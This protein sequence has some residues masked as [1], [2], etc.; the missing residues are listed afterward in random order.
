MC[1]RDS[2]FFLL[3]GGEYVGTSGI[4]WD[5]RTIL[6]G[7]DVEFRREGEV[8]GLGVEPDEV[9]IRIRGSKRTS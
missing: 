3:R 9:T 7:R 8:A 1:I 2:F 5:P 4:G 6:L